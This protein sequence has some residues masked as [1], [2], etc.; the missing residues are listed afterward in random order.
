MGYNFDVVYRPGTENL[1]AD[2][3]SRDCLALLQSKVMRR[4]IEAHENLCHPGS[5]RLWDYVKSRKW[6]VTLEEVRKICSDCS[7]CSELKPKFCSF[8]VGLGAKLR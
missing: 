6:A 4:V 8:S 5:E 7:I 3:L 1:A 2:T